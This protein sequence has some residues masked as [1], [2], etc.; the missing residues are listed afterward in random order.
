MCAC[1]GG[2]EVREGV[3]DGVGMLGVRRQAKDDGKDIEGV[4]TE[5]L[6]VWRGERRYMIAAG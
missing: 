3:E 5:S 2:E 4:K 1:L 6:K